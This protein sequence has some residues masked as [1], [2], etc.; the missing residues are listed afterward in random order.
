MYFWKP[1]NDELRPERI[2]NYE[3]SWSHKLPSAGLSY[4]VNL[5]YMKAATSSSSRWWTDGQ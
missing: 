4:G 3:L 5:Y 2:M 1:A